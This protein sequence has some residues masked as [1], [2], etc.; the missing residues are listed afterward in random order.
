MEKWC[1]YHK[2]PWHKIEECLSKQSLV[3]EMKDSESEE[4]SHSES[5]LVGGKWIINVKPSAIVAT[6]K[7][8][9]R[10]PEEPKEGERL[11]HS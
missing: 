7:V 3:V 8:H 2:R 11:F 5:N 4:D 9:P 6:N 1:E 10:K